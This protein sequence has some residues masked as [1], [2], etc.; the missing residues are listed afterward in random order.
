MAEV[1]TPN[2]ALSTNP[3][4][5]SAPIGAAMAYLGVDG[6]M[7]IFHGSQG[8]TAFAL[9]LLVRH[10]KEAVPL[11]T[12]AM[13]EVSTILGGAD[14]MEEAIETLR[15][16][17]KPKL[18]GIASTALTETRGEDMAGDLKLMKA[19]HPEWEDTQIVYAS[20]PDFEGAAA[21]GW[22]KAVT[23]MINA[24]AEPDCAPEPDRLNV[25]AGGH[26]TP[27][28]L[29]HLRD[30]IE[31]FG[32]R[33]VI[34]PDIG[35]SLD[36]H[37]P[38]QWVPVSYGGTSIEDIRTLGA[39]A[40]TL[41]VGEAMLSPAIALEQKTGQPYRLFPSLT[42]LKPS[43]ALMT[44]LSGVSGR[45]VPAR[46]KRQRSQLIDASL[47]CHFHFAGKKLG[48]A[49]EPDL[50]FPIASLCA[51][52][53]AEI[54]VAVST[55]DAGILSRVPAARVHV[56]DLGDF[57]RLAGAVEGGCDL[58]LTHA[59]GRQASERLGVPLYRCGFPIF[60]RLGHLHR[61]SIGYVGTRSV[62]FELANLFLEQL[63][64]HK[65]SDWA[66]LEESDHVGP[67]AQAH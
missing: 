8:C 2:K 38:D 50:L 27:G 19:R 64:D 65:P 55:V 5:S 63:H 17:A 61:V 47:D 59:H 34:L 32:L 44:Y 10:F 43:D 46:F 25:L 30:T 15:S 45:P 7:P 40:H 13:N 31:A 24:I 58:L 3:L 12:T 51:S 4:K 9:V 48:V 39:A 22:A 23:A 16:R 67:R 1:I 14:Q 53:G 49:A 57:E 56:G 35:S 11:Q 52:L 60:D 36:G 29:E 54:A 42:G 41:V 21:Q 20:T 37:V 28:D 18:I 66:Y 6:A 33:P 26:L 62:L